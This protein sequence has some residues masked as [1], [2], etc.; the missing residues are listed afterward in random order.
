MCH[1]GQ[2]FGPLCRQSHSSVQIYGGFVS[3]KPSS[4]DCVIALAQ[5]PLRDR[6]EGRTNRW[7]HRLNREHPTCTERRNAHT[8]VRMEG[9]RHKQLGI[10]KS[11]SH[12]KKMNTFP[13]QKR[14][15]TDRPSHGRAMHSQTRLCVLDQIGN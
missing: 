8:R 15:D 13:Q 5:R 7:Q 14:I 6:G 1:Y 9:W 3:H 12:R 11:C 10:P 4:G 2:A